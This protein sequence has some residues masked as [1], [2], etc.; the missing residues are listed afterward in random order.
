VNFIEK[1]GIKYLLSLAPKEFILMLAFSN[2]CCA[3]KVSGKFLGMKY[4]NKKNKK[5]KCFRYEILDCLY[6]FNLNFIWSISLSAEE[7][8]Q[9]SNK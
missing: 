3:I 1:I 4:K 5:I 6:V 8:M 2:C 7:R 9:M